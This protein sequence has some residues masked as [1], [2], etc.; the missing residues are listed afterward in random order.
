MI[1]EW[2]VIWLVWAV[3]TAYRAPRTLKRWSLI[4]T[5]D[6]LELCDG[7]RDERKSVMREA[8]DWDHFGPVGVPLLVLLEAMGWYI[9]PFSPAFRKAVGK[10]PLPTC[11]KGACLAHTRRKAAA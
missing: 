6:P 10:D 5:C 2:D 1:S 3:G 8:H 4:T 9:R 11:S 7:C